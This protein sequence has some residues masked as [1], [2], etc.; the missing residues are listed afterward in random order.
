MLMQVRYTRSD[1]AVYIEIMPDANVVR[2]GDRSQQTVRKD[3][4]LLRLM[5]RETERLFRTGL[6][7][8]NRHKQWRFPYVPLASRV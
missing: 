8:R 2:E 4:I 7:V 5:Q 1:E 6:G 3:L